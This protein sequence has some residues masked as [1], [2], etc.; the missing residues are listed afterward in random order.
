MGWPYEFILTLDDEAKLLRRESLDHYASL[1]HW[2]A[3]APIPI[4]LVFSVVQRVVRKRITDGGNSGSGRYQ[5]VPGSPLA[6]ARQMTASGELATKWRKVKWWLEDDLY[7]LG[8]SRGQKG[9]W[10][11]GAAWFLWLLSL[12]VVGTGNGELQHHLRQGAAVSPRH[13]TV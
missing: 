8:E 6:K 1:A 11:F 5:R 3:F 2:S 12:C 10:L 4:F 7:F 9:D 13:K